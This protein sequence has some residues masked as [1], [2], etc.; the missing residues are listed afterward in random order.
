MNKKLLLQKIACIFW[1]FKF[2]L[3]DIHTNNKYDLF[4]KYFFSRNSTSEWLL[5]AFDF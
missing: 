4:L 5:F 2:I 3:N 1:E